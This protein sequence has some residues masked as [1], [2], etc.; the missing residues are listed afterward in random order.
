MIYVFS[1]TGHREILGL[2][3]DPYERSHQGDSRLPL[4]LTV[5][6]YDTAVFAC[7]W[8]GQNASH[9]TWVDILT[10]IGRTDAED[11]SRGRYADSRETPERPLLGQGLPV[12]EALMLCNALLEN[13]LSIVSQTIM[14]MSMVRYVSVVN[15]LANL[16]TSFVCNVTG[17]EGQT[18]WMILLTVNSR[19]TEADLSYTYCCT[20]Q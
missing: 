11:P 13:L 5:S 18:H 3:K 17:V 10:P 1:V 2:Q 14:V 16:M 7:V 12:P 8:Q 19:E 15:Y 6:G 4:K 20:P 9:D